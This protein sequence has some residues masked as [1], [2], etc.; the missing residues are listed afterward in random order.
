V[1]TGRR[2]DGSTSSKT[3]HTLD[4]ENGNNKRKRYATA[5]INSCV[6]WYRSWMVT[7]L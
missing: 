2:I 5:T 3:Q 1:L 6:L 4:A 7:I